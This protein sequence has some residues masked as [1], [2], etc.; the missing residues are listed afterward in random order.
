MRLQ[1]CPTFRGLA[2]LTAGVFLASVL[3]LAVLARPARAADPREELT[4]ADDYFQV[5]DF[6]TAL[7]KVQAL[8]DSGDLSGGTLRDAY[9]LKARC[10]V[11]LAHRSSA[12]ESFCNALRVEPGWRPDPDLYTKDELQVFDQAKASCSTSST[13]PSKQPTKETPAQPVKERPSAMPAPESSGAG[14]EGKPFYKKPLFLALGGALVVG[15]IIAATGGGSS[16]TT[17]PNL[18]DF[19]GPPQ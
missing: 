6:T 10:E 3:D 19:P 7:S 17:A 11:G 5:A 15:G 14:G 1:R 16:T 4:K 13:E 18:P 12:V 2:L 9:I 8:I